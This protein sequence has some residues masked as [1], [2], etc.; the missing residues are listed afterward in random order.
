LSLISI[1]LTAEY[2][3]SSKKVLDDLRLDMLPGE[4]VGLIGESGSGKSTLAL[5]LLRLLQWKGGAASGWVL[6]K[7]RDLLQ[8]PEREMREVRGKEIA[9]VL[10]SAATSLNPALKL[11]TQFKEAWKAHSREKWAMGRERARALLD[12][13]NL[14]PTGEFL[15]RYPREVSLGQAQR[16]LIALSLLHQPDLMIADEPTSALDTITQREVLELLSR[17]RREHGMATLFIS[18]DLLSV[19]AFCDRVAILKD[20]RIVE[21]GETARIFNNPTHEYTQRLIQALPARPVMRTDDEFEGS[22]SNLAGRVL[23]FPRGSAM[24]DSNAPCAEASKSSD[25]P[26]LELQKKR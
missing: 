23:A 10:Q 15:S 24:L 16:V 8:I 18:H 26:H 17:L 11:E 13:V 12:D 21:Q 22:L 6:W 7:G 19:G 3:N 14:P 4:A 5:A 25:V 9:L 2:R 20:G 1:R